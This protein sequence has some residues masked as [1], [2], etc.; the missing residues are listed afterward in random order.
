LKT[1]NEIFFSFFLG[2]FRY[3]SQTL[4]PFSFLKKIL[5]PFHFDKV[6]VGI[7]WAMIY[8]I[9]FTNYINQIFSFF[10]GF[11]RCGSQTL[12]PFSFLKKILLPFHFGKV[13]VGV[14]WVIIY[15]IYCLYKLY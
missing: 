4:T 13:L 15:V 7:L 8:V 10:L 11:F 2:F 3:G 5:L 6:L 14:L 1:I 9:A 12:T